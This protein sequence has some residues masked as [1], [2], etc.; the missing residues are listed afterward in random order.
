M[1]K[2][3]SAYSTRRKFGKV[4]KEVAQTGDTV[5]VEH[6]RTPMVKIVPAD[7]VVWRKPDQI[8]AIRKKLRPFLKNIDSAKAIRQAREEI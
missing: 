8:T 1:T 5:V 7:A 4:I 2:T 6:W 3:L